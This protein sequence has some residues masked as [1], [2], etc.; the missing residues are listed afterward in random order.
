MS[1]NLHARAQQLSLQAMVEGLSPA[2]EAWLR[3]H[4]SSCTECAREAA[5]MRDAVHALRNVAVM[6]P[7]DLAARTQL[8]LRLRAQELTHSTSGNL[9]L[10][11]IAAASWVLGLVS[12]PLVWQLFNWAGRSFG[13][14][15]LAME[16]GFVLWWTVPALVAAGMVLH[17]RLRSLG[18]NA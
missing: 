2:E 18:S 14:P 11:V 8:R 7:R 4:Q 3:E 5:A 17:Q 12:A 9:W 16:A 10:W 15:K 1:E 6:V 13:V